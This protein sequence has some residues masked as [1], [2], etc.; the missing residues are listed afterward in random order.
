LESRLRLVISNYGPWT[1]NGN[2][3]QATDPITS[4]TRKYGYD[5]L[6]RITSA[7][8]VIMGTQNPAPNGLSEN[9]T[10]DAFGNL[11]ESGNF[12]FW[13]T[14][15][16]NGNEPYGATFDAAGNLVN[17]GIGNTFT[18][19]EEGRVST[20]NGVAYT[21]NAVPRQNSICAQNRLRFNG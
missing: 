13:P 7:L 8:D 12:T 21:Y 16:T 17:D 2:L 3:Q 18:W 9:F 20:A 5:A 10:Y 11:W 14:Q 6:N 19:D 15:Y 1:P 4:T